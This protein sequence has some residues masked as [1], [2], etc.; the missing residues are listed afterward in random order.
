MS[1]HHPKNAVILGGAGF[2]GRYLVRKLAQQNWNISVVTR[3]PH[4]HRDFLVMPTVKLQEITRLDS[5][6]IRTLLKE[7]DTVINLVGILHET[8]SQ[9]F[10]AIHADLP[11]E[12]AKMG[13][14]KNIRRLIH[15][16]SLGADT[17]APSRYLQTKGQGEQALLDAKSQGLEFDI[18]RPSI[19]YGPDDSF[20][21]LFAKMLKLAK[22]VFFVV[23]PDAKMQPVY[24]GD[25]VDCI[26]HA[27]N[28]QHSSCKS[29]DV[30]GPDIFTF[31]ELISLIDKMSGGHHRLIRLNDFL[32]RTMATFMQFTPGKLL[33]P[34]NILS[35]Q[36]PNIIQT[37]QPIPYGVQS[38]SF[39]DTAKAWLQP[40]THQLDSYR[41]QAGR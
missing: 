14:E 40:Q 10:D 31:Y 27:V 29:F 34:D 35:L 33:T 16:S 13:I 15:I 26:M 24:V 36:V 2:V 39:E 32:S 21:Q 7:N 3:R 19:V 22:G 12:V 28:Q 30:A 41:A 6:T 4:R 9:T 37:D 38:R 8:K 25:L 1:I 18:I 20:T 17:N 11:A 5:D 23:T